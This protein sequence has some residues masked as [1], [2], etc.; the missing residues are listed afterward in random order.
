MRLVMCLVAVGLASPALAQ[1]QA[2]TRTEPAP[3]PAESTS[4]ASRAPTAGQVPTPPARTGDPA[5]ERLAKPVQIPVTGSA[6][7]ATQ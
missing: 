1:G 4:R 5:G 3:P 7:S 6:T 2:P